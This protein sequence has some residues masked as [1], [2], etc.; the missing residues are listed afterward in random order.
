LVYQKLFASLYMLNTFSRD[1]YPFP[2]DRGGWFRT[3]YLPSKPPCL[4]YNLATMSIKIVSSRLVFLVITSMESN[5]SMLLLWLLLWPF[6][7]YRVIVNSSMK[8][9]FILYKSLLYE[10]SSCTLFLHGCGLVKNLTFIP[11]QESS[12]LI[13]RYKLLQDGLLLSF[14]C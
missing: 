4:C 2:Y 5:A 12:H 3:C 10:V 14:T 7:L 1:A 6:C 8:N 9:G 13:W 11:L